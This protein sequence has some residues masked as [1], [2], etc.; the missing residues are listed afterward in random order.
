MRPGASGWFHDARTHARTGISTYSTI[1]L[2]SSPIIDSRARKSVGAIFHFADIYMTYFNIH[3][4]LNIYRKYSS[5][6]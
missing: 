2:H 1:A 6:I 3:W 5:D 4:V